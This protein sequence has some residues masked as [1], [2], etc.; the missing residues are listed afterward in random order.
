M[1]K[2]LLAALFACAAMGAGRL[3]AMKTVA[4]PS[5]VDA[6]EIKSDLEKLSF[7]LEKKDLFFKHFLYCFQLL[8]QAFQGTEYYNP[9][10]KHPNNTQVVQ[11]NPHLTLLRFG[12]KTTYEEL[13]LKEVQIGDHQPIKKTLTLKITG[14]KKETGDDDDD[15]MDESEDN[16]TG[17][18]PKKLSETCQRIYRLIE[19]TFKDQQGIKRNLLNLLKSLPEKFSFPPSQS[20]DLDPADSMFEKLI[21]AMDKFNPNLTQEMLGKKIVP[22]R[23]LCLDKCKVIMMV[24]LFVLV[25]AI[26]TAY[27]WDNLP[28]G[29]KGPLTKSGDFLKGLWD[30]GKDRFLNGPPSTDGNEL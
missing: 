14:R 11:P 23:S 29:I 19:V 5:N 13:S 21:D 22:R 12:D 26:L 4:L 1:K 10:N 6:I 3:E 16:V 15:A 9:L 8:D 17:L 25:L 27:N 20:T 30:Q 18:T 24:V 28:N 7:K 2:L